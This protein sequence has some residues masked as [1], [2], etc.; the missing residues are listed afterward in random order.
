MAEP[1]I[2]DKMEDEAIRWLVRMR[3][4]AVTDADQDAFKDWLQADPSHQ[5]AFET[6]DQMWEGSSQL[7]MMPEAYDLLEESY[8][9]WWQ[10]FWPIE[11][12]V[13]K[14]VAFGVV[15]ILAGV[16]YIA[17]TP[18]MPK[19]EHYRTEIAQVRELNLP[20]GSIVALGGKTELQVTYSRS[21]RHIALLS[22]E[23]YFTPVK[24][25][26]RPFVVDIP[27][28]QVRVVGTA[29]NIRHSEGG[30]R[31]SVEEGLVSVIKGQA[32]EVDN[33][34]LVS[35]GYELDMKASDGAPAP[36]QGGFGS[37]REGRFDY[38]GAYLGDIVA[39]VNRYYASGISLM[40][41]S[42]ASRQVTISFRIDQIDLMAQTVAQILSL[43][44]NKK[45]DGKIILSEKE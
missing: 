9:P 41:Q 4:K 6:V 18:Q 7:R 8:A 19:T 2:Q 26:E 38:T 33:Y 29:F 20:D 28:G 42:L 40:D 10:R 31:V 25:S 35:A 1:L 11:G 23:A 37:W 15:M 44:V 13:P 14:A 30:S 24:N 32:E 21:E 39:D 17:L 12:F 34:T 3:T 5:L 22:G 45:A 16:A 27:D 36:V 43:D